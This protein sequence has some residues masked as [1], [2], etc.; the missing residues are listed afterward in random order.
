MVTVEGPTDISIK[1]ERMIG[2]SYEAWTMAIFNIVVGLIENS[3][4]KLLLDAHLEKLSSDL[5]LTLKRTT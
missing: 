2:R 4:L 5:T 1:R 3:W